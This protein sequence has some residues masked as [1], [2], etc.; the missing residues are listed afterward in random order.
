M[1]TACNNHATPE[2][3]DY[4]EGNTM[5]LIKHLAAALAFGLVAFGAAA[6]P[7]APVAGVDYRVMQ[8]P[9]QTEPG[10]KIE[11]TEFFWY[12]CPHCGAFEPSIEAWA[13]KNAATVS[14]KRVPIAFRDSFVPQQ[15]LYYTLEAMGKVDALHGKVFQA[16][17]GQRQQIDTDAA[18]TAFVVKQGVDQKQFTDLYNS[19]GVQTK[20]KRAVQMQEAYGV[21]G[22]PMVA[23]D[24]KYITAPSMLGTNMRGQSEAAL[25][26][27][28]LTVMDKLVQRAQAEQGKK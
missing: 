8:K 24:G 11:V 4:R 22:V 12:S 13:K 14:F 16:I 6:A 10:K 20:V 27:A 21:D 23:I 17:H 18:I 19:F 5:K 1:Q 25:H 9:Q 26:E 2:N 7:S 3:R 28:T 15:K